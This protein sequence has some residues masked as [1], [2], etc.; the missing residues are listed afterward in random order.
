MNKI[1]ILKKFFVILLIIMLC[2]LLSKR[3]FI[4]LSYFFVEFY[5]SIEN[6]FK[7]FYIFK[8]FLDFFIMNIMKEVI[9]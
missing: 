3:S 6:V 9:L 4:D 1:K 5:L 7:D 8:V 2:F